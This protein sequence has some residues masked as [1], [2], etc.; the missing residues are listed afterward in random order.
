MTMSKFCAAVMC[1]LTLTAIA[2]AQDKRKE[3]RQTI[4]AKGEKVG[5]AKFI[6]FASELGMPITPLD[7]LGER[8]DNARLAAA[9]IELAVAAK[10]LAAVENASGKKASLTSKQITAEAV[11]LAKQRGNRAELETLAQLVGGPA[12]KDLQAVVEAAKDNQPEEGE[13]PRD[14]DGD[15]IVDNHSHSEVHVYVDGREVGHVPAHGIRRFH[16]HHAHHA[17]ARDHFGH[18]WTAHFE[19]KHYHRYRMVINPPH[20]HH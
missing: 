10:L 13:D 3:D 18:R 11:E 7:S 12:A 19:Y 8:I 4:T 20:H 9:P 14:L 17:V 16:V 5:R 2:A 15:L 6:D 1:V